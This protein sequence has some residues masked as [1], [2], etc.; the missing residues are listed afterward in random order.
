MCVYMYVCMYYHTTYVCTHNRTYIMNMNLHF[1]AVA[2]AGSR[3][4]R[5]PSYCRCLH[6]DVAAH[7]CVRGNRRESEVPLAHLVDKLVLSGS[8]TPP[9]DSSHLGCECHVARWLLP[10]SSPTTVSSMLP[11][12]ILYVQVCA[13]SSTHFLFGVLC[14][15]RLLVGTSVTAFVR[16]TNILE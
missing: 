5:V 15:D 9:R 4:C 10:L 11:L 3:V 2:L 14:C 7:H 13:K 6:N 12:C 16:G 1:V 8:L